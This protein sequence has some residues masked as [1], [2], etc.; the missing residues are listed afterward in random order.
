MD[1]QNDE[2]ANEDAARR[3]QA[4]MW[5]ADRAAAAAGDDA[6]GGENN[7]GGN[8]ENANGGGDA[9]ENNA[10]IE[11]EDRERARGAVDGGIAG[12]A[13]D[14]N[15]IR[16]TRSLLCPIVL[17][18]ECAEDLTA[19]SPGNPMLRRGTTV[20][21]GLDKNQKLELVFQRYAKFVNASAPKKKGAL[22]TVDQLRLI[23]VEFL[24]CQ[25]LEADNTVEASAMM[26][27]DRITVQRERS[28][29]RLGRTDTARQQRESDRKY[30]K[31]L[32]QLLPNPSPEGLGCDAVLD[33][34]GKL[35]DERGLCQN[36]LATTVR[37]NSVLIAK[38]CKWLG[39]KIADAKDE[40]R[41]R[42][43]MTVP[44][45]EGGT[46]AADGRPDDG[47]DDGGERLKQPEDGSGLNPQP[48]DDEGVVEQ[49]D[50]PIA[51]EPEA[52][53]EGS[54]YA[55]KV[56]D[57]EDMDDDND[58]EEVKVASSASDVPKK[59]AAPAPAGGGGSGTA[60]NAVRVP[61]D[62][63][64]QAVKL[65]LE[66]CYTNRVQSLG[67]EAFVKS[68]RFLNSRDVGTAA[69]KQ[70]GPVSPFR[71]HEWPEGGHPTV[72]LHLALAGIALA[73]EAHLP[74]LS[75][76]CEVAASQL[77][78]VKSVVDV[79]TACSLQQTKTGNR[80]PMLRKAAM[81]DCV[82]GQGP[83]GVEAC[84]ANVHFKKGM[85][86]RRDVVVPSLLEGSI[87][88]MPTNMMSKDIKRKRERI[89]KDRRSQFEMFDNS[90][91]NKRI[92]ER[93]KWRNNA[94]VASRIDAAFGRGS[95]Q[96]RMPP[97]PPSQAI[98]RSA[99]QRDPPPL[100]DRRGSKR[101]S[102]SSGEE[103]KKRSKPRRSRESSRS[104][105]RLRQ[106]DED[107]EAL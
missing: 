76:M 78:N 55:A 47:R 73:E 92:M 64:P 44:S 60:P 104:R 18:F 52:G 15:G 86:D 65:L 41:R 24:H 2:Q 51:R 5:A 77:V 17:Y 32:R 12:E 67:H 7:G 61:L 66:Y 74:R 68:S 30:F 50:R 28:K 22:S 4:E 53:E 84:Y 3:I 48:D 100:N 46:A 75:L 63:S 89:A 96:M 11:E 42:A 90:D 23:D 87:E 25:L 105:H 98:W 103:R 83:A 70:S 35:T 80:L 69:A 27:N 58:D 57:D 93:I 71:K 72:S 16:I 8:D 34:R 99:Y 97:S 9:A 62:H 20:Y 21:I 101:K 14:E 81:L 59:P 37:A 85:E 95:S 38:R 40:L 102:S 43:E 45:D 31:D 6:G 91:K 13:R 10:D 1:G 56:E 79:L 29:E 19:L 106:E 39:R 82:L 94:T 36:V 107:L 33:C 26:K 54:P 49:V 88:V